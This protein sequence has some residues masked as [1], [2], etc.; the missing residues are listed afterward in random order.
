MFFYW[1]YAA[2]S[3]AETVEW[4]G[5]GRSYANDEALDQAWGTEQAVSDAAIAAGDIHVSAA[6]AAIALAGTPAA[7]ELVQ[8]RVYR[9]ISD[10]NLAG[11]ALLLGA[12]VTFTRA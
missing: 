2:G 11:D 6:T 10:D 9:D 5:Q 8:F 1:T 7:S 4:N 12:M 3:P